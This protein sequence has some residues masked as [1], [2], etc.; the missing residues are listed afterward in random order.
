V[1]NKAKFW[2][3]GVKTAEENLE[4]AGRA[5]VLKYLASPGGL[6]YNRDGSR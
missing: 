3:A 6:G 1:R 2:D 5:N 4:N